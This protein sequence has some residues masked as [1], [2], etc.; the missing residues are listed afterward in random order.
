MDEFDF[1]VTR[2]GRAD[3]VF[4]SIADIHAFLDREAEGWSWLTTPPPTKPIRAVVEHYRPDWVAD[5]RGDLASSAQ[6][7]LIQRKLHTRF[8]DGK[9]LVVS[10]PEYSTIKALADSQPDEPILSATVLAF[11]SGF[12]HHNL[13]Q[14]SYFESPSAL[15]ALGHALAI[16]AG[17]DSSIPAASATALQ[18]VRV[19]LEATRSSFRT[20]LEEI[21]ADATSERTRIAEQA[22]AAENERAGAFE[23]SE[24]IRAQEFASLK[25]TLQKTDNFYSNQMEVQGAVRYWGSRATKHRETAKTARTALIAFAILGI[26]ALGGIYGAAAWY[27]PSQLSPNEPI[28]LAALFKASAFGILMTTVAF[29]IGRIILKIYLSERHL[30]TDSEERRTMVMTYLALARSKKLAD[31]DKK[32]IFPA[33]FRS[34]A[35]GIVKDD[36]SPDTAFAA[37]VASF[38]K[39]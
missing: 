15:K 14:T 3:L 11:L 1:I 13:F 24:A 36:N 7:D 17:V 8:N 33:I 35:D 2:S 38:I 6:A 27:L 5:L 9:R 37:L 31:D 30:A 22:S 10:D 23:K 12:L 21:V 18:N 28:P 32:L 16:A 26:L 39:K 34:S 4:S 29:W 20:R 19:E 25:E